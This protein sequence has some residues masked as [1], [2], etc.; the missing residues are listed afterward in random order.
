[1]GKTQPDSPS[2][3]LCDRSDPADDALLQY[4]FSAYLAL[5]PSGTLFLRFCGLESGAMTFDR[6]LFWT[7]NALTCTGFRLQP[8]NLADFSTAG[9]VGVFILM[10]AGSLFAL[11]AGGLI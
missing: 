11:M 7:A 9:H 2:A 4:L 3:V 10:L 1:M 8:N 6:A 5:I